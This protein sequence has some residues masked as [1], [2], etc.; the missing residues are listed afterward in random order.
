MKKDA[1]KILTRY[2]ANPI[3][4]P[5]DYPGVAQF[6]NPSPVMYG[7]ETILLVSVTEYASK[8]RNTGRCGDIHG[9]TRIARSRDGIH[10]TVEEENFIKIPEDFCYSERFNHYI[11][12]RVT[13]IEDTYYIVTPAMIMGF[14]SP[15]AMLGKTMDFKAY[16]FIDIIGGPITRG[17][18]LFPEKI[19]GSYYKLDRPGAGRNLADIWI[20]AS[21]DL[22]HWGEFKP[23]Q[24]A[25]Y[26]MWN[27]KKIGPTPPVKTPEGWLVIVHGVTETLARRYSLG[28]ILLD[29]EEP[30]KVI[31]KTM[32]PLLSPEK[33]Y[34]LFGNAP[35][36][37]FACG[38][39]D[40]VEKDE[41]RLYYGAA[42]ERICLAT[43]SLSEIVDACIE[44]I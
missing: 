31:G 21:P 26:S 4:K 14:T 10:F 29:L 6:Y 34:E 11:D 9:Q 41:L 22:L 33:E 40:D 23:V 2:E 32:S 20:S 25:D 27:W 42:D 18:S 5:E 3:I 39:I 35:N 1:T 15:C 44:G 12:N 36:C 24:S 8:A 13:K 17:T 30:W 19:N 7:E 16:E 43:G 37:V 38:V 28:A